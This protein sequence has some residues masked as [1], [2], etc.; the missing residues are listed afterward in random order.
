MAI[1][2]TFTGR[3]DSMSQIIAGSILEKVRE[4]IKLDVRRLY[5]EALR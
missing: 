4:Q 5:D 1:S 2:N 3:L